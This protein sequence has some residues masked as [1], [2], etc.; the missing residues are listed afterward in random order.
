M[1][2]NWDTITGKWKQVS[3]EVKK[4][5]GKLTEDELLEV[6][7]DREILAGKIQVR[8]GITKEQANRQIDKWADKLKV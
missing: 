3:G 2:M 6:N 7:G 1:K 4:Q 5:W 8:Y